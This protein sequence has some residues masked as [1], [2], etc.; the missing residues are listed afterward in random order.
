MDHVSEEAAHAKI[1]TPDGQEC[2]LQE[3]W[4]GRPVVI[5]FVRHFGCLFCREQVAQLRDEIHHIH[6]HGA[7]LV[8]IGNGSRHFASA[9]RE[10]LKLDSPLYVD[11]SRASYRALGMRRG[12]ARTLGSWRTWLNL[13]RA[14]LKGARQKRLQM[15]VRWWRQSVPVLIPGEH[16]DAWQL[17]GVLLVLPDGRI[18][19]Q[20]LSA[21]GG[22]HP[23]VYEVMAALVATRR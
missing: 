13:A 8:V 20:Y 7:E 2:D 18:A 17:G 10:A 11:T 6:A 9:F 4:R 5:A 16:G 23:P 12:I 21:I 19:Y 15:I 22:D 1:T 3:A 14:L